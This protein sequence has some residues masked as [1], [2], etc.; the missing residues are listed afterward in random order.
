VTDIKA[1]NGKTAG[2]VVIKAWRV[3]D[4]MQCGFCQSEQIMSAMTLL[5]KNPTPTDAEIDQGMGGNVCH[6]VTQEDIRTAV[7]H[8]ADDLNSTA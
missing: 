4:A 3:L 5:T 2:A 7:R 6:C 1:N 8:A